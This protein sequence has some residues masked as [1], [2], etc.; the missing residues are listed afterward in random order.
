MG[1]H[2]QTSEVH[3]CILDTVRWGSDRGD[4][5]DDVDDVQVRMLTCE[6]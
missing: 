6:F 1:R 4:K 5:T 2:V 3:L